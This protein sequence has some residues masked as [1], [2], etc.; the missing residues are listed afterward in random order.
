M[1]AAMRGGTQR[2]LLVEIVSRLLLCRSRL[3]G[4][5]RIGKATPGVLCRSRLAGEARIG[6]ATPG[7]RLQAGSLYVSLVPVR[8][9]HMAARLRRL[10]V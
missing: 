6:E 3:A 2:P 1:G 7:I 5:G 8:G 4:E 9:R 10:A